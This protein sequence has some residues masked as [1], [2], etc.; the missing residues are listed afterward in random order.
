M[1]C[2]LFWTAKLAWASITGNQFGQIFGHSHNMCVR[3]SWD[4]TDSLRHSAMQLRS[5]AGAG[6]APTCHHASVKYLNLLG[7][8]ESTGALV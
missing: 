4:S 3:Y 8:S 2:M 5:V 6:F 1:T 7:H